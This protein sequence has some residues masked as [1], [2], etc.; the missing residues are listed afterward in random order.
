MKITIQQISIS[1]RRMTWGEHVACMG[2]KAHK[3]LVGKLEEIA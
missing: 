1:S 2:H 3:I